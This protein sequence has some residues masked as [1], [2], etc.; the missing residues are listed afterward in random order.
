MADLPESIIKTANALRA[1]RQ[2]LERIHGGLRSLQLAEFDAQARIRSSRQLIADSRILMRSVSI[3]TVRE[4]QTEV[5][6]GNDQ[7]SR[8][9]R[10]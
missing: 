10:P 4:S 2:I 5:R 9:V 1:S 3:D 7:V 8:F 6:R